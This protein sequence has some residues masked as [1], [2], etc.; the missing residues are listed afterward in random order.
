M[1]TIFA[2]LAHGGNLFI[3]HIF[4]SAELMSKFTCILELKEYLDG[5]KTDLLTYCC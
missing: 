2:M 5:S 1:S 3:Q 4:T